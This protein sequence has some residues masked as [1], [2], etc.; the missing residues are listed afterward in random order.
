MRISFTSAGDALNR[1]DD[2]KELTRTDFPEPVVPAISTWGILAIFATT[3]FPLTSNPNETVSFDL[4]LLIT[5]DSSIVLRVTI[6]KLLFG[7][8]IPTRFLPGI[9]ASI[10]ICPVGASVLRA[11]SFASAVILDSFVP[12]ATSKAY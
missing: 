9:G 3:G 1:R 11:K 7:I 4:L 2:I 10:L 5:L 8:S 6:S 12:K